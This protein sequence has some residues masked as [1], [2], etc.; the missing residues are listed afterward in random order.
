MPSSAIIEMRDK[1]SGIT[2]AIS[3]TSGR[4]PATD[5]ETQLEVTWLPKYAG[6][7]ELRVFTITEDRDKP[8]SKVVSSELQVY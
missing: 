3:I 5:P 4:M 1:I 6:Q 2:Q 7:F 8:F